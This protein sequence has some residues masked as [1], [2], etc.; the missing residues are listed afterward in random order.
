MLVFAGP[1]LAVLEFCLAPTVLA[2][3]L[4]IDGPLLADVELRFLLVLTA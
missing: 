4:V 1:P 3:G 2:G